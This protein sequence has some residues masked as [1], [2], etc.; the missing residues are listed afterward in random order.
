M[1]PASPP[2]RGESGHR[3]P[4]AGCAARARCRGSHNFAAV[5]GTCDATRR[6]PCHPEQQTGPWSAGTAWGCLPCARAAGR[7]AADTGRDGGKG[8]HEIPPPPHDGWAADGSRRWGENRS[9]TP[10]RNPGGGSCGFRAPAATWPAWWRACHPPRPGT[11]CR[12]W[13]GPPARPCWTVR[14]RRP[15]SGNQ[16]VRSRWGSPGWRRSWWPRTAWRRARSTGAPGGRPPPC[17]CRSPPGWARSA[18]G[19][20]PGLSARA[21][22]GSPPTGRPADRQAASRADAAAPLP[23]SSGAGSRAIPFD[24]DGYAPDRG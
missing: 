14:R 19:D 15:P 22:R 7:S 17:H 11:G 5:W 23:P 2:P 3:P 16:T 18:C 12:H 10:A 1:P 13:P 20:R 4:P 6:A 8:R 9:G 21:A 24:P